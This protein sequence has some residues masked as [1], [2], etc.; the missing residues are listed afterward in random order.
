MDMWVKG[1][2]LWSVVVSVS[3]FQFFSFSKNAVFIVSEYVNT[4]DFD[5]A[6]KNPAGCGW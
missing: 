5:M 2:T 4:P 1:C 3:V 6:L